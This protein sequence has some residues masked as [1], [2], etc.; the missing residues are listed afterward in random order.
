[1]WV[2]NLSL[3]TWILMCAL[4]A[5][6]K[7]IGQADRSFNKDETNKTAVAQKATLRLDYAKPLRSSVV[8]RGM[9]IGGPFG[10]ASDGTVLF[11]VYSFP[12]QPGGSLD[13]LEFFIYGVRAGSSE[14]ESIRYDP[15]LATDLHHIIPGGALVVSDKVVGILVNAVTGEELAN[16]KNRESHPFLIFFDRKG[17]FLRA[18]PLDLSFHI[19]TLGLLESGE[20]LVIGST[21]TEHHRRLTVLDDH[22]RVQRDLQPGLDSA[23][24]DTRDEKQ[25][26]GAANSGVG[27]SQI[28]PYRDHL[29][30]IEMSTENP[31]VELNLGGM[32][33]STR[34][35]LPE[36]ED[37]WQFI[38]SNG[39][40]WDVILGHVDTQ[41]SSERGVPAGLF[42][43][44]RIGVFDP[45]TGVMLHFIDSGPD[46]YPV[47]LACENDG[48]F[49]ALSTDPKDGSLLLEKATPVQ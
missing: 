14:V 9:S 40:T 20:I 4:S 41:G 2:R 30:L 8:I 12:K 43:P 6:S 11:P 36:G 31:I 32:V 47:S 34:L 42:K 29:L 26:V 33:K 15:G 44:D 37:I 13:A 48:V 18:V 17:A 25:L 5:G 39:L 1:M 38:P 45:E 19:A 23:T 24:E 10:C 46:H 22:G 21:L 16:D 35:K 49:I 28:V 3:S 27:Q 7:L